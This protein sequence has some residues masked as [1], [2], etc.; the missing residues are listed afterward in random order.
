MYPDSDK[1]LNKETNK[2][3]YFFTPAFHPLDNFSAHSI[4]VWG[5][6]FPTVEHAFHWKKFSKIDSRI[7]RQI[8]MAKSPYIVKQISEK[9][10]NIVPESWHKEKLSVM[11]KLLTLKTRQ[12]IDVQ[13][14]LRK[15]K[16]KDLIEN[17]PVDSFWGIGP[18]NNGQNIVGKIWME[19]RDSIK[20]TPK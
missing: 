7:A 5:H 6:N 3:I 9:N 20:T 17:S 14:I 4:K 8:L 11:K 16:N 2:E 10:K 12:H 13:M 18:K 19:I 15:T 1:D